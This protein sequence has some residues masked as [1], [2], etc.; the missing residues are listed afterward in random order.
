MR[1]EA[2]AEQYPESRADCLLEAA[3]SWVRAGDT[4][5]ALA[6]LHP[7]IAEGGENAEYARFAVAD[8]A[9]GT[10]DTVY[11]S[12]AAA[13]SPRSARSSAASWHGPS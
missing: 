9:F 4:E 3:A 7:L 5:R 8:I 10:G 2:D 6:L 13:R 11:H 12:D 1:S